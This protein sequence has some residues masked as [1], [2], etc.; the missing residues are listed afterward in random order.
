L[1][2]VNF[3][4]FDDLGNAYLQGSRCIDC[5]AVA[6]G[7]RFICNA[8]GARSRMASVRLSERGTLYSYTIVHRSFPD[9]KTPFTAVIVDLDGGGALK[10]RLLG[11][12]EDPREIHY[13]M[14]VKVVYRDTGQ[15]TPDGR[16]F[17]SYYFV[18]SGASQDE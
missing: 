3:L 15:V 1:P 4:R 10:G 8:C 13:G 17:C 7:D 12:K 9:V 6:P 11:V 5:G 18:P 14:P 2:A 16:P